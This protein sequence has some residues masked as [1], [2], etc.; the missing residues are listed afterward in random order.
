MTIATTN[1]VYKCASAAYLNS[2][3]KSTQTISDITNPTQVSSPS[4]NMN[5]VGSCGEDLCVDL[6]TADSVTT[7]VNV[8]DCASQNPTTPVTVGTT[9]CQNAVI[10]VSYT[11]RWQGNQ[12]ATLDAVVILADIPIERVLSQKYKVEYL[13]NVTVTSSDVSDNFYNITDEVYVRSG[14]VGYDKG[15]DMF[16]GS[17][18]LNT[19][20][21]PE[22]LIFVNTN[23][24]RQMA[25]FN[26]GMHNLR[27]LFVPFC[28]YV[29]NTLMG[30]MV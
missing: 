10:D 6:N 18:V 29:K 7:P 26:P 12:I 14:K 9:T 17:V 24:S 23:M 25:V 20:V 13:H 8:P 1:V 19:T 4:V 30:R 22:E 11:V 15:S 5:C 3:L 28:L 16:S 27:Y 21:S 2:Y